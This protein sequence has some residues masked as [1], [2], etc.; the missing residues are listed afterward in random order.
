MIY[1]SSIDG[2]YAFVEMTHTVKEHGDC[3]L[4]AN[5]QKARASICADDRGFPLT[6]VSGTLGL[7]R[8]SYGPVSIDETHDEI[9]AAFH[10]PRNG[11]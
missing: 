5:I 1:V 10:D 6:K 7:R 2:A 8:D 4:P 9:S 11:I 3:Q